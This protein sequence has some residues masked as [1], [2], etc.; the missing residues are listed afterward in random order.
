MT[1]DDV[2]QALEELREHKGGETPVLM[3][4]GEPVARLVAHS[5][6]CVYVSDV[7]LGQFLAW[8]LCGGRWEPAAQGCEEAPLWGELADMAPA[9]AITVLPVGESPAGPAVEEPEA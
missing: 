4:D 8:R 1:I 7:P 6:G 3:A 9:E 5:D 2:I